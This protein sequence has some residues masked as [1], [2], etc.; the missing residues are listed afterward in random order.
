MSGAV[1]FAIFRK[2]IEDKAILVEERNLSVAWAKV[3]LTV[4]KANEVSP[5]VVVIR[6]I[7]D[8]G[9][10]E[11]P[12]IRGALD[13][14]LEGDRKGLSCNTV[15][16]TIFPSIWNPRADR[17]ELYDRYNRI[18]PKLRKHQRNRYGL[19]FQRLT[20]YS[21]DKEGKGGF[22]QLE[23]IIQT[24]NKGN[25]RRTAL[26]AGLFDPRNDHTDQP[27]RG[28]PCLQQVAFAPSQAGG[29]SV[30]GFYATQ[31]VVERAYGN[32][33]GLCRLG[34][35]MAHEMGL[36]FDQMVCIAT[37]VKLER[38]KYSVK[39]LAARVGNALAILE[40]AGSDG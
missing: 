28:F 21:A 2:E 25:H 37:P 14:L 30:T 34:K 24:W 36:R 13:D 8:T 26:Q 11:I 22:N 39:S 32:Y 3:F 9:P 40:D 1:C 6:D 31:Y 19:Y 4:L 33:L 18:L 12:E 20:S 35:F 7:S 5:V 17:Q 10:E 23:H 16:N 38:P 27:I 15:A 29:L